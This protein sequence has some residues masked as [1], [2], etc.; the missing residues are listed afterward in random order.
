[1]K[2]ISSRKETFYYAVISTN[3]VKQAKTGKTSEKSAFWN[4]EFQLNDFPH[5]HSRLRVSIYDAQNHEEVGNVMMNIN[6]LKERCK[7]DEWFPVKSVEGGTFTASV[8]ISLMY[9]VKRNTR[10]FNI[11]D[12][13]SFTRV[14]SQSYT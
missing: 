5:C 10:F 13:I 2:E 8:K 1:M 6:S 11:L 14:L 3:N 12:T 4:E 7:T 9:M